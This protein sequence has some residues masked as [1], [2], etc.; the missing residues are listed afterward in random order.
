MLIDYLTVPFL[1]VSSITSE[2][3]MLAIFV[4]WVTYYFVRRWW[5]RR[6]GINLELAYKEVPP[7]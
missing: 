1:G 3:I 2:A 4:G 6:V 7:V 5:L